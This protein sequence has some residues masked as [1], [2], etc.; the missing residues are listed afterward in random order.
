VFLVFGRCFVVFVVGVSFVLLFCF[1][2]FVC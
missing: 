1:V 2:I